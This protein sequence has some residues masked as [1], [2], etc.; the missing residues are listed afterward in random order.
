MSESILDQI[1]I[2]KKE[3]LTHFSL[4]DPMPQPKLH[5]SLKDA[6]LRPNHRLGLIAEVKHASPSKGIFRT[7]IS[8]KKLR[9]SMRP[10]VQ[11]QSVFLRIKTIFMVPLTT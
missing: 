1:L 6:L 3:E 7:K 4:P 11:T 5:Y 2:T 9:L 10:H 8:A